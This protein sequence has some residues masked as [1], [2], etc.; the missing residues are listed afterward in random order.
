MLSPNQDFKLC[1]CDG[2][3]KCIGT[4]ISPN[5]PDF[6][7]LFPEFKLFE[8]SNHLSTFVTNDELLYEHETGSFRVK[9]FEIPVTYQPSLKLS[10]LCYGESLENMTLIDIKMK[11]KVIN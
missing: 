7:F 3:I 11:V 8:S 9:T 4:R 10:C 2:E 5:I 1:Q 6:S